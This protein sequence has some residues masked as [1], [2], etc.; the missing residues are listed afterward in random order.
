MAFNVF[1]MCSFRGVSNRV[2]AFR[3]YS[4]KKPNSEPKDIVKSVFIS[5]SNDIFTNLALED[6][7]Y[8]NTNFSDQHILLLWRNDPCVVIGR[9]QNPWVEANIPY[10]TE[11]GIPLARRNSGGGTVYHDRGNLN[12]SFFS[13]KENYNRKYNLEL[14]VRALFREFGVNAVVNDRHDI[15]V[16]DKYKVS[17]TAAKLGRPSAYH[18][19]TLLVNSNKISLRKSLAK[20]EV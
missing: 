5:Q 11:V 14:I 4:T 15:I 3:A 16:K 2:A 12:L 19:C 1:R 20:H 8:K 17:G 7:M 10:L 9:H 6:W 13:T 18:H